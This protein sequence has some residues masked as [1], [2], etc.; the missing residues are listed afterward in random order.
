LRNNLVTK[1]EDKT[2]AKN[3]YYALSDEVDLTIDESQNPLI[4]S[5]R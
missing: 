1:F 5:Q 4:I 3:L 2:L